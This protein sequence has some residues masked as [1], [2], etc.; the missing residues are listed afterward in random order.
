MLDIVDFILTL[1]KP[2]ESTLRGVKKRDV[3]FIIIVVITPTIEPCGLLRGKIV[4]STV[5]YEYF[6]L[7]T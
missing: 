5:R 1:Q 3:Q 7:V 6:G 2:I 4:S